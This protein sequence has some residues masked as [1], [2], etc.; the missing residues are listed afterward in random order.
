MLKV[1]T[2]PPSITRSWHEDAIFNAKSEQVGNPFIRGRTIKAGKKSHANTLLKMDGPTPSDRPAF[3][4]NPECLPMDRAHFRREPS[5]VRA[6][7]KK[8]AVPQG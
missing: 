3:V 6:P 5:R 1:D 7:G 8:E 2:R 4:A